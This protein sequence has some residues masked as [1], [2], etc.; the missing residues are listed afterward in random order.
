VVVGGLERK[1]SD[2]LWL[3]FSLALAKPN[4]MDRDIKENMC[5]SFLEHPVCPYCY[6]VS[7]CFVVLSP[8][9]SV[10]LSS[11]PLTILARLG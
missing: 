11:M 10:G 7:F 6:R 5:R 1:L 9:M 4:N 8:T 2:Q 3:S